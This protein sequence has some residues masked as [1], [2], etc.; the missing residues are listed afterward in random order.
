[1]F[2]YRFTFI[3]EGGAPINASVICALSELDEKIYK[4]IND[5]LSH[6]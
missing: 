1:M 2:T 6:R 4:D 5:A 3:P